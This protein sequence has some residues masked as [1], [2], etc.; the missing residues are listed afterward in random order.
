MTGCLF[1]LHFFCAL[2]KHIDLTTFNPPSL[3]L[4]KKFLNEE[5]KKTY[6]M[7]DFYSTSVHYEF[8]W[9]ILLLEI[10][11]IKNSEEIIHWVFE[12]KDKE[13]ES[14]KRLFKIVQTF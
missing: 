9:S 3:F 10:F 7:E 13:Q 2:F 11:V 8:H 6:L 12:E 14:I 4:T 5:G 1:I